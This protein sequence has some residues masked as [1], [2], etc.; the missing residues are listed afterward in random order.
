MMVSAAK[1]VYFFFFVLFSSIYNGAIIIVCLCAASRLGQQDSNLPP[2][3]FTINHLVGN[4]EGEVS[5]ELSRC[6]TALSLHIK[7]GGWLI[8]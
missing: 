3:Y 2:H 1:C 7:P 8:A 4:E 5:S 6:S